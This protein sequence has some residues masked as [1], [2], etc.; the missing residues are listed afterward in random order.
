MA[1]L[2]PFRALRPRPDVAAD[3]AAV[4]YDVV[5]TEDFDSGIIFLYFLLNI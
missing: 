2:Q 3:V 4:P 5:S 1:T